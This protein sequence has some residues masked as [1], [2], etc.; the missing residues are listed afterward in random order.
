VGNVV[1]VTSTGDLVRRHVKGFWPGH[2]QR[3]FEWTAGPIGALLPDFRVRRI[4]PKAKAEP[5][6]YTTIG[7]WQATEGN[8]SKEFFLLSPTESPAHVETLAMITHFHADPHHRLSIGSAVNIGRPWLDGAT[9]DNLLVSLPYPYGPA[10]E[11][12]AAD[13]V[14]VQFLWLVPITAEEASYR[15]EHGLE[16]LEQLLEKD[17]VNVIDPRRPSLV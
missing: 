5:W 2:E 15:G 13:G 16:A 1:A 11:H 14:H 10:L 9:A 17:G 7:A 3:E 4:A 12:C 6:V 8:Q